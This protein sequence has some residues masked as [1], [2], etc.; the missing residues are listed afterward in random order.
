MESFP[1]TCMACPD[2]CPCLVHVE[3]G[4]VVEIT[5]HPDSPLNQGFPPG[6]PFVPF[7]CEREDWR[8]PNPCTTRKDSFTR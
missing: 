6:F 3:N 5:G 7:M 2:K 4:R 8:I 1:T